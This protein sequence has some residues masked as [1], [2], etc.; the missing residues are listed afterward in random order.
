MFILLHSFPRRLMQAIKLLSLY[1]FPRGAD[2]FFFIHLKRGKPSTLMWYSRHLNLPSVVM[3]TINLLSND[4]NAYEA[5][6]VKKTFE[7]LIIMK[8]STIFISRGGVPLMSVITWPSFSQQHK[9]WNLRCL[10]TRKGLY[11]L[12]FHFIYYLFLG[13][14]FLSLTCAP[15]MVRGQTL[16]NVEKG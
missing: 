10:S 8:G 6:W 13:V 2:F 9:A 15:G 4:W 1:C 3:L 16:D 12:V 11:L 5:L 14:F 7:I